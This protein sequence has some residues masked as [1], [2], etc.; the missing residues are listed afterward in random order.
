MSEAQTL[1]AF[2]EQARADI[3]EA[4]RGYMRAH[5]IGVPTLQVRII[6]AD[7]PRHR[8]IPLKTLQRFIA[9]SHRTT[10]AYVS[11]CVGFLE[12]QGSMARMGAQ[13]QPRDEITRF[14]SELESYLRLP[15]NQEWED[16]LWEELSGRFALPNPSSPWASPTISLTIEPDQDGRFIK[17]TEEHVHQQPDVVTRYEGVL[18]RRSGALFGLLRN[19]LTCEP[20]VYWLWR[21]RE[22]GSSQEGKPIELFGQVSENEFKKPRLDGPIAHENV[23]I[24][25]ISDDAD[26]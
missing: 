15:P 13:A 24:R 25:K 26:E 10:D 2:D 23:R 7:T 21:W 18:L 8:E 17:V 5:A 9:G 14:G 16:E 11:L 4:I 19:Q 12:A 6:D 1:A 20:R 3:R 22:W